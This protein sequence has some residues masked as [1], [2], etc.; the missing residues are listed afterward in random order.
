MESLW[1]A[2]MEST[3]KIINLNGS[4]VVAIPASFLRDHG[5]RPGDSVELVILNGE[6]VMIR[7]P[8]K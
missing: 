6:A 4:G 8:V 3:R 5:L 2:S 7:K 1:S